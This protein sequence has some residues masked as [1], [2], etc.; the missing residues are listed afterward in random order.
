MDVEFLIAGTF[1]IIKI[2]INNFVK[3]K[4]KWKKIRM[5]IKKSHVRSLDLPITFF[6][7]VY[8]CVFLRK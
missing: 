3:V 6:G 7:H 4:C 2:I 8:R 1:T 5:I